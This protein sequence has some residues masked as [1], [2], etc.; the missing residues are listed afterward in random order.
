MTELGGEPTD[1]IVFPEYSD[2]AQLTAA[3]LRHPNSIV[4]GAAEDA[5]RNRGYLLHHGRNQIDYLKLEPDGRTDGSE[6][7]GQSPVYESANVCVGVLIC[8][9][10]QIADFLRRIVRAIRSSSSELKFLCVSADMGSEWFPGK[11]LSSDFAGVYVVVCNH[12]MN[13]QVRCKSFMTNLRGE[14][15]T[16]QVDVEP[17]HYGLLA[18]GDEPERIFGG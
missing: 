12:T 15:I 8:M 13:H 10:I 11:M 6:D 2:P 9:D 16:P 14:K 18:N 4:V 1:L 5:H 3:S 17:I 7:I